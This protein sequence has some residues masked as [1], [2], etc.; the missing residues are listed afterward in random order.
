MLEFAFDGAPLRHILWARRQAH[1]SL[2]PSR[3]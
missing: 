1:D 2:T 3:L